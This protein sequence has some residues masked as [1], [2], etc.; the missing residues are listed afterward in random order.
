MWSIAAS[1]ARGK[2]YNQ[3]TNSTLKGSDCYI[4]ISLPVSEV[5]AD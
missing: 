5:F 1:R 4:A 2:G 3:G